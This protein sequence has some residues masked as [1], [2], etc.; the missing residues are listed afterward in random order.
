[1]VNAY[2]KPTVL[3]ETIFII[4]FNSTWDHVNKESATPFLFTKFYSAEIS[5]YP[6]KKDMTQG[7]GQFQSLA[8][9]LGMNTPKNDQNFNIPDVVKSRLIANKAINQRW[10]TKNGEKIKLI[11]LW[12]INKSS[13]LSI[14]NSN[15][16]DSLYIKEKAVKKF[17]SCISVI[18]DRLSGLIRITTTL[19]DPIIAAGVANFIGKEV[20]LYIQKENSAQSTK[21]KLFISER[22]S[23]VK[24]ELE[25]SELS[26]KDF[27]ERN[28]GYEDSPELFMIFSQ[29]F[30]EVEGVVARI[31]FG[32]ALRTFRP[33]ITLARF[34]DKNRPF[35]QMIELE[36]PISSVVEKLDVYESSFKS[37]KSLHK[38]IKTYSFE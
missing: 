14:F 13:L 20:Q 3:I 35:S 34:K 17:N 21:E 36:E 29:L 8:M 22:L 4:K 10:L 6:A 38:L 37:G 31:G 27:K 24:K 26:L 15:T 9:N 32:M 19:E 2:S 1:M 23:I 7:L 11:D 5:L 25:F 12:K 33:H 30:R 16:I 28:R 18:E